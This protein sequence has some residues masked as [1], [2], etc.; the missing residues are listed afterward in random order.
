[1]NIKN[2]YRGKRIDNGKWVYGD[3]ITDN[4]IRNHKFGSLIE[5]DNMSVECKFKCSG[6]LVIPE[7]VGQLI[8][9]LNGIEIY[10]GDIIES[11]WGYSGIVELDDF[12]Y[13]KKEHTISEF[14]KIT[15]NKYDIA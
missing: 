4:V 3:L 7:T 10:E 8:D 9:V 11:D 14:I 2:K 6:F 1:M 15:G 12:I 13:A 5:R